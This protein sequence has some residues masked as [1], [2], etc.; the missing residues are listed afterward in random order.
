[1]RLL[2]LSPA[3]EPAAD[4]AQEGRLGV[5][6][7][8]RGCRGR[9]GRVVKKESHTRTACCQEGRTGS[10][11]ATPGALHDVVAAVERRAVDGVI[12]AWAATAALEARQRVEA[13]RAALL[14][15]ETTGGTG[16]GPPAGDGSRAVDGRAGRGGRSLDRDRRAGDAVVELSLDIED[17]CGCTKVRQKEGVVDGVRTR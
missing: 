7:P 1:M 17:A 8:G 9:K 2:L 5:D 4:L 3:A 16:V 13:E 10:D 11:A 12:V 14:P 6:R 15:A